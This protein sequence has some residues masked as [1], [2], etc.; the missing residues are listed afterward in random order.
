MSDTSGK[1]ICFDLNGTLIQENSWLNL[2]LAMGVTPKEDQELLTLYRDGKVTYQEGLKKLLV[3][4]EKRGEFNK[5]NVLDALFTYTYCDGAKEIVSHLL[6][7][8]Y[9]L[10][11]LTGSFDIL[12]TRIARE[13][14]IPIWAANNRFAF[15]EKG[16]GLAIECFGNDDEFK[17]EKLLEISKFLHIDPKTCIC[18]GDSENDRGV[19]RLTRKGIAFRGSP[20]EKDAWKVIEKLTDLTN[21]L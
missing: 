11:I 2:N 18:V 21:I 16:K 12:A 17:R 7:K 8:N 20:V 6:K 19:F 13:L 14:H 3:L 15:D 9:Q 5:K 1:L 4:Y 10:A